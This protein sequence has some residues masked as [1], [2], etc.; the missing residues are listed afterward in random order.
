[1]ISSRQRKAATT[2]LRN[3]GGNLVEEENSHAAFGHS[4]RACRGTWRL[5]ASSRTGGDRGA[6][7][8]HGCRRSQT[9]SRRSSGGRRGQ[10]A[11]RERFVVPRRGQGACPARRCR[12]V[13]QKGRHARHARHA[14]LSEPPAL[15]PKPTSIVPRP[16][17]VEARAN[18]ARKA[19]LLKDGWTPQATYDTAL[20]NLRSAE[21]RLHV[22]QG[23][24][25][26]D[27]RPAPLYGAQ[28][29]FRR[30]DHCRE[31]RSRARTL[32]RARRC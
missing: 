21:A 22:C 32:R 5:Q 30:R 20:R 10:A 2:S 15:R 11:L 3:S 19:K 16:M 27:P 17:L 12:S 1:M 25:R 4:S 23:Q 26:P 9:R 18:E 6:L 29:R 8:P 28:G 7:G 13:G 24:S 14:G 31:C